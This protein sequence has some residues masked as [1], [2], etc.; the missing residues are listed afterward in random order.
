[1]DGLGLTFKIVQQMDV[2]HLKIL[3]LS[4]RDIYFLH[5]LTKCRGAGRKHVK[6][7]KI[8]FCTHSVFHIIFLFILFSKSIDKDWYQLQAFY[9]NLNQ[10]N[11]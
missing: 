11:K 1:M 9:I 3:L 8:H 10:N 6:S 7:K 4:T 2:L 5:T